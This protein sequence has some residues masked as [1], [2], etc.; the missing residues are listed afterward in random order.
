MFFLSTGYFF[1]K[2]FFDSLYDAIL[3]YKANEKSY[4]LKLEEQKQNIL[5]EEEKA[6]KDHDATK[7]VFLKKLSLSLSLVTKQSYHVP[8]QKKQV[9]P[10]SL[11][12]QEI[13]II[14]KKYKEKIDTI[15]GV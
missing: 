1:L 12:P 3:L 7:K 8:S 5:S 2:Y 9:Q 6:K 10:I 11:S 15:L 14:R 13:E 4:L